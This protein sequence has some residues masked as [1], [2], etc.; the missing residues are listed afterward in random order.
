M[1]K[2]NPPDMPDV[3]NLIKPFVP[4]ISKL[5]VILFVVMFG[6]MFL[7]SWYFET[8]A[9]HT[10]FYQNTL[11]GGTNVY[12]EPGVHLRMPYFSRITEYKQVMTVGFGDQESIVTRSTREINVRFADTYTGMITITFRFKLPVDKEKVK[13]IHREFRGFDNLVD[14]LLTKT[15]RDVVVNTSTQYTGEEFFQGA[16]NQFKAALIDQL[17]YGIY[18]TERKQVEVEQTGLAPV[19]L[20]Q[21]DSNQL[22][23]STTLVWKTVPLMDSSGNFVRLDNP[24]ERYGIEVTQVTIGDTR[25]EQQLEKLLAEKKRLVADRIKTVQEQ[26]T[27]KEQAKTAQLKAEIERTKAKQEA[28]KQKELAV[29]AKQREVEEAEKQADKEK[30]EQQK[31]KDLAVIQKAKE[32]EIAQANRDIQA[33]N[34]EAAK[35]E[36]QAIREKGLAEADVTKARYNALDPEIYAAEL[37]RDVANIIYPNLRNIRI[38]MPNNVVNLGGQD[39]KAALPT[40]LDVLSSFAAISTMEKLK[41][42]AIESE[43]SPAYSVPNR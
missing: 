7:G 42:Q 13:T 2:A 34:Y 33:A 1:A 36:A 27:A 37:Q 20:G 35:F 28:L 5:V 10:Y 32:L 40:N 14:A 39:G 11:T 6:L 24:L 15:A 38:D 19:G 8:Q 41:Q 25:P 23:K 21:E 9:G 17:R 43:A 12:T 30:I 22:R 26:E 3:S 29:I 31:L 4:L 18:K 16:L